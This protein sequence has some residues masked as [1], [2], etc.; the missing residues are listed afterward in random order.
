MIIVIDKETI[1][2]NAKKEVVEKDA[3]A[4]DIAAAAAKAIKDDC[5]GE[6][7]VAMPMLEA[8]LNA[9]NTLTKNDI[10]EVK[11]MKSPPSG[12]KLVM[13]A[14]CIMK[15][16][17]PR[18]INDPAGGVKK[19]DDYWGPSASLLAEPTFLSDLETYD[20]DNIDPKIVEKIRPFVA[21]PN[22]EPEVV[23]KAS[24]VIQL[25]KNTK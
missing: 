16:I 3:A 22:F 12:V 9:L 20:K 10:T 14:V 18:K 25:E 4:A 6:L 15:G 24:K 7:A 17:K 1:V 23:K 8:A 5:E 2:A 13:E 19:V 11:S 21:D